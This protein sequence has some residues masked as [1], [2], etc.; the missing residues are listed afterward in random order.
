VSND[1]A[2]LSLP[3]WSPDGKLIAY[4][5]SPAFADGLTSTNIPTVWG[6]TDCSGKLDA[7]AS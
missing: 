7:A 1:E 6:D 2:A 3:A 4:S 5:H